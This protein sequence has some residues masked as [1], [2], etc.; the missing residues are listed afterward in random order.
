MPAAQ[1]HLTQARHNKGL[2][3][4]SG[5]FGLYPLARCRV[6]VD[7]SPYL[8]HNINTSPGSS[9]GEPGAKPPRGGFCVW[10]A[11]GGL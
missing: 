11:D 2:L 3:V 10:A 8:A 9:F 4:F 7:K 1:D 5:V 6:G